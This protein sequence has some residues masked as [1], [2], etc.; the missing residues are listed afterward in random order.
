MRQRIVLYLGMIL[1]Q[2]VLGFYLYG[3]GERDGLA[4]YR[5]S[6]QFNMTLVSEYYFGWNDGYAACKEG[7]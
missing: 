1:V 2:L 6:D 5:R 7:K 3:R 4:R